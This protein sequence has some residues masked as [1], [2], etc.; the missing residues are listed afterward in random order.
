LAKKKQPTKAIANAISALISRV[1]NSIKCSISGALVASIS[2][3]SSSRLMRAYH[4][5]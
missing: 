4:R 5:T 3:S 2:F 1:R